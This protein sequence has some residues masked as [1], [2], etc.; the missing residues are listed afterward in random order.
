M[1]DYLRSSPSPPPPLHPWWFQR[2]QI[3]LPSAN[4]GS[5]SFPPM[6]AF[7]ACHFSITTSYSLI[8]SA[9]ADDTYSDKVCHWWI[10][11]FDLLLL[12]PLLFIR[13]VFNGS[14]SFF[15]LP[16]VAFDACHF[17]IP[18]SYSF[19]FS[20]KADDTYSDKVCLRWMIIF[21]PLLLLPLLLI[22]DFFL[23]FG[24]R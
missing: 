10:I 3:I 24:Y 16:M 23:T 19:I 13:D 1:D 4:G 17:S 8:F 9:K 7:D 2:Q 14:R 18:T 5:F 11:I 15:F 6:V 22:R 21:D 12:L 20:A